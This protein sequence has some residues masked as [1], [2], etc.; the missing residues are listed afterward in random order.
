MTVGFLHRRHPN[1]GVATDCSWPPSLGTDATTRWRPP[2]RLWP[3][4]PQFPFSR[5]SQEQDAQQHTSTRMLFAAQSVF[6][7]ISHHIVRSSHVIIM[8]I[9]NVPLFPLG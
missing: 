4:S 7:S 5:T 9:T 6:R 2:Q 8:F 3:H 1:N